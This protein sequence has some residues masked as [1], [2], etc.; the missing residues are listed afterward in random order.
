MTVTPVESY[1]VRRCKECG[2]WLNIVEMIIGEKCLSCLQ[3]EVRD[4]ER[5]LERR[6]K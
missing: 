6:S 4:A 2:R 1:S 3:K 5:I